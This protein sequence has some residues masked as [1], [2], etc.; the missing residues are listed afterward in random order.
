M[1]VAWD[2]NWHP[3]GDEFWS[4]DRIGPG[5]IRDIDG[6][7]NRRQ[8]AVR[9]RL[10]HARP[11]DIVGLLLHLAIR[12]DPAFDDLVAIQVR[13]NR[14]LQCR[15]KEGRGLARLGCSKMPPIGT[16]LP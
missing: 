12:I 3:N 1:F 2:R 9:T 15:D 4:T 16:P 14:I 5:G 6:V 8:L 7:T 13:A 10:A 11:R